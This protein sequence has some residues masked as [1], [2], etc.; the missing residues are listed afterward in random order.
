VGEAA[1]KAVP[2]PDAPDAAVPTVQFH[3][4]PVLPKPAPAPTPVKPPEAP[5]P[6]ATDSDPASIGTTTE[7]ASI[8]AGRGARRSRNR[9]SRSVAVPR[10]RRYR[11]ARRYPPRYRPARARIPR[12]PYPVYTARPKRKIRKVKTPVVNLSGARVYR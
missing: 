4:N 12:Y 9:R 11:A 7:K 2:D 1:T 5:A 3:D 6:A 8:K 10:Y